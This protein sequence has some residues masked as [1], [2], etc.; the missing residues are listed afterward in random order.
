MVD[1]TEVIVAADGADRPYVDWSSIVAGA[2][3]AAAL[4]FVLFSFGS[5][6]GLLSVSPYSWNNPSGT[7]LSILAVAWFVFVMIFSFL[8][9][10]YLAGRL[11]RSV[12]DAKVDEIE[13]RDG[14]QG[15]V[16][17]ALALLL[18]VSVAFMTVAGA[19]ARNAT[20]GAGQAGGAAAARG[21]SSDQ[22]SGYVDTMLRAPAGAAG[23]QAEDPRA[24]IGRMFSDALSK[25]QMTNED[26]N[27]VAQL[28]ARRTGIPQDEARRRVDA[29]IEGAKAAADK[30][31]K[32]AA[33][34][35][36]L[37]AISSILSACA[38]YWAAEWGGR[39]RDQERRGMPLSMWS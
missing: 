36:F 15:L 24:E 34:I 1:T 25:G 4:S 17:W 7:A 19:A 29:A 30:A 35:A 9:G 21:L 32:A 14:A 11:G 13:R 22:V 5:G 23:A 6:A 31:R 18:G 10:G 37:I 16:M 26:R 27:Y 3:V 28:I 39:H 12:A 20:N 38:A 8:V 2:A 33:T